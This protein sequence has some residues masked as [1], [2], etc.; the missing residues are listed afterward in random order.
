MIIFTP[1]TI[2][3]NFRANDMK[4]KL[5]LPVGLIGGFGVLFHFFPAFFKKPEE[6]KPKSLKDLTKK[7]S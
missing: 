6:E 3:D 2:L 4:Q 5:L 7:S 1:V